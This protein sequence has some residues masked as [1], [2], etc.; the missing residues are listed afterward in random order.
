MML[1]NQQQLLPLFY[2]LGCGVWIGIAYDLL[3]ALPVCRSRAGRFWRDVLFSFAAGALLFLPALAVTSGDIRP[4]MVMAAGGAALMTHRTLGRWI[5]TLCK[6]LYRL[7]GWFDRFLRRCATKN[8]RFLQNSF[9]K[10][11][12][13]SKKGLQ[14]VFY[15]LYN[16]KRP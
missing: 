1:S 8:L 9:K 14:F 5:R 15:M 7:L 11:W 10:A 6:Q 12:L 4:S 3:L 16:K 2:G 13:F